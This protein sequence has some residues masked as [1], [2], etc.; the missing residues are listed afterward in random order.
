MMDTI[1]KLNAVEEIKKLKARYFRFVDTKQWD[2]LRALFTPD[3]RFDGEPS[4]M[5]EV[6]DL[7]AFIAIAQTNLTDC[8]SAHHGHC[9]E[10]E[11]TS[12]ST[13]T[14][15]WPMEDVLRWSESASIP[16]RSLHGFGH[17]FEDYEKIGGDWKIA[18]W[19]LTR[20][21]VDMVPA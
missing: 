10:I 11:L 21:R 5:G 20:L 3:A 13:A 12:A 2:A 4:G 18:S 9:P 16:V 6:A 14:G 7:D 17:Y 1:E 15:I 8:V 19:K